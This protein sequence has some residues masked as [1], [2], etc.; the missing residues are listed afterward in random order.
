MLAMNKSLWE[1]NIQSSD[2][3][4]LAKT[5]EENTTYNLQTVLLSGNQIGSEGAVAFASMLKKNQCLDLC[6]DDSVGVVGALEL[7]ES[8]KHNT[9]LEELVLHGNSNHPHFL[10]YKT[11]QD[12]VEFY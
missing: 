5:L 2:S 4:H 7:I 1:C 12:R 8:L 11:M 6:N 9:T 3:A 10:T